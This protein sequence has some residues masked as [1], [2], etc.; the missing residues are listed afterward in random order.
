MCVCVHSSLWVKGLWVGDLGVTAH[1]PV[2]PALGQERQ[3][4][5]VKASFIPIANLRSSWAT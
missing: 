3:E 5:W 4:D 2:I 1:T